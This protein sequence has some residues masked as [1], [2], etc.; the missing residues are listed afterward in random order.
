MRR[1]ANL[2]GVAL[3]IDILQ[4]AKNSYGLGPFFTG[5]GGVV[6]ISRS[7]LQLSAA[8]ELATGLMDYGALEECKSAIEVRVWSGDDVRRA[9]L[10]RR[11]TWNVELPGDAELYGSLGGLLRK[12][13]A[14]PNYQLRVVGPVRD[15]W[16]EAEMTKEYEVVVELDD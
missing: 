9:E 5:D 8:S 12:F 10:A 2:S 3:S 14:A 1:P 4:C 13:G 6:A 15:H 11:R 16:T 7:Q